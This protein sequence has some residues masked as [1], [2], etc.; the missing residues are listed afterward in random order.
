MKNILVVF[1]FFL[2][3]SCSDEILNPSENLNLVPIMEFQLTRESLNDLKTN[4]TNDAEFNINIFYKG[5]KLKGE[6]E[7]SGA[8]S[9]YNPRWSYKVEL[10]NGSTADGLSAF[11][12]SAQIHDPTMLNTAI[13]L[14]YYKQL[15]L[16]VFKSSYVFLKINNEDEALLALVERIENDFFSKR[17]LPIFQLFKV[18]F[19]AKFSFEGGFYPQFHFEKK[20][21][22]DDSYYYLEELI[23]AVDTS[24]SENLLKS[25]SKYLDIENYI[26]YHAATSILNNDDS[27]NNNFYLIKE[28]IDSPFR[29]IPWD[30]DKCFSR[31]N[32]V[33]FAGENSIIK[34]LFK[35]P[36]VFQMYKTEM[37]YQL[38]NIYTEENLFNIIDSKSY[39]IREAYNIDPFLGKERY[40]F[41]NEIEKLKNYISVRRNYLI[42]NIDKLTQNYFD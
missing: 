11:N 36:A 42:N 7:A 19:G 8:G 30:F 27:F 21:P 16:P 26:K 6:L 28:S 17:D 9:R 38:E 4:R 33:K 14:H 29:I 32:D 18:G 15:G 37:V 25:L 1:L 24:R 10:Q 23:N 41:E 22:E 3:I 5:E 20:I 40:N 2:F 35:N 31:I 34:K 12:L 13:A 39:E